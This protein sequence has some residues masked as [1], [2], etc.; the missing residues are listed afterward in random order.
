MSSK[1][2]KKEKNIVTLEFT[3]AKEEF[4]KAVDKAYLKVRNNIAVQGFRKGKAPKHIIQKKY[5]KGIFDEEALDIAIQEA[6]PAAVKDNNLDVIDSPTVNIEKF[7]EGQDIVVTADVQV[8]PEVTLSEYKGVEVERFDIKVTD[9]DVENE[10]KKIQ[11]KNAR[12]VEIT[13][14]PVQKGDT[15]T[16][17]YAGFVGEEQFEGGTAENQSL[18]IGS[19]SFIPGFEEQLIGKNKDEEVEIN[20]TFPE[21]YHAEDLK[22]K[23]AVFKVK[24][25]EIKAKELP[26]IDDEL[27]KDVSEFDTLEE[28]KE[29]TRKTL[30]K[31][32]EDTIK[33]TNDNNIITKIVND[34]QVEI[35]EVL[36]QREIDYLAKNYEQ[37]FRSQ[38]FTGKEYDDLI[39]S[40]VEQYKEGAGKQAEFNVKADLVLEAIVKNE[41]ISVSEEELR[42]EAGKIASQYNTEEERKDSFINS[43]LETSGSY[44]EESIKKRKVVEMLV[45]NAV[46][47]DKKEE[48]IETVE[49]EIVEEN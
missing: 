33:V 4:D 25:H 19:N 14:R 6:Y 23:D 28:L 12:I 41:N 7:E 10:L 5:G 22:G 38:G 8:M 31:K 24:I 30:E 34:S 1:I 44:I 47:V 15:L 21:E 48:E 42:E 11:E 18:E 45:E 16:I 37:Q 40:F 35:P 46:L 20:V 2:L 9:E 17:D 29:D 26:D 27:A 32:A 13:D 39:K 49:A 3:I 43:I 36:I